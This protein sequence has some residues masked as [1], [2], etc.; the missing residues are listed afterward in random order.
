VRP[1]V[2]C[3]QWLYSFHLAYWIEDVHVRPNVTWFQW[4]CDHELGF[5]I[6]PAR[7]TGNTSVLVSYTL[8]CGE[9]LFKLTVYSWMKTIWNAY[10]KIHWLWEEIRVCRKSVTYEKKCFNQQTIVMQASKKLN[11]RHLSWTDWIFSD[12]CRWWQYRSYAFR[13]PWLSKCKTKGKLSFK[14]YMEETSIQE[15]PRCRGLWKDAQESKKKREA[16]D[17]KLASTVHG[18]RH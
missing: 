12:S 7:E 10:H 9:I 5:K 17:F 15:K 8:I 1:N 6:K 3:F 4:L 2:A 18:D 16:K 11:F 13:M 14:V